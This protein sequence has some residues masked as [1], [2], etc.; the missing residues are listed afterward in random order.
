MC[1]CG[2]LEAPSEKS[3][4][5]GEEPEEEDTAAPAV[6]KET[7]EASVFLFFSCL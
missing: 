4:D 1:L 5:E 6:T 3:E 2:Y 7:D